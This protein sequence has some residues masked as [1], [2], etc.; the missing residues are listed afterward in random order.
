M[1]AARVRPEV[2]ARDVVACCKVVRRGSPSTTRCVADV[3]SSLSAAPTRRQATQVRGCACD[4]KLAGERCHAGR[5]GLLTQ[6]HYPRRS[7]GK[8][9]QGGGASSG[10]G[11]EEQST[12]AG[13][14]CSVGHQA[15]AGR[16]PG[17]LCVA[18]PAPY[19]RRHTSL[20]RVMSRVPPVMRYLDAVAANPELE[21]IP[22][23]KPSP[24]NVLVSA[25]AGHLRA[26]KAH[27]SDAGGAGAGPATGSRGGAGNDG[28][29]G[30]ASVAS[31]GSRAG[32]RGVERAG[33]SRERSSAPQGSAWRDSAS[34]RPPSCDFSTSSTP[35]STTRFVLHLAL[36]VPALCVRDVR[37]PPSARALAQATRGVPW[38]G[39]V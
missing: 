31:G 25:R 4:G 11:G 24:R 37:S 8:Q 30:G 7:I 35:R 18:T 16:R 13:G 17:S 20:T 34:E 26:R 1:S 3:C 10:G 39:P 5:A 14:G 9:A 32:D 27:G 33:G 38:S 36:R 19:R 6:C 15:G 12:G 21:D 2:A 28:A 23:L 22:Y 29:G